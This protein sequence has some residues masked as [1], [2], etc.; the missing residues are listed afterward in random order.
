MELGQQ[1]HYPSSK[2]NFGGLSIDFRG[3]KSRKIEVKF[4]GFRA[5]IEREQRERRPREIQ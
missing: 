4:Y 2:K 1:L 5:T 3:W